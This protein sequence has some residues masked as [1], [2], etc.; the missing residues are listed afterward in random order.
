MIKVSRSWS[1]AFLSIHR[2]NVLKREKQSFVCYCYIS[3]NLVKTG[4]Q[5]LKAHH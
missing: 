2:D 5:I 1:P 4:K 3:L